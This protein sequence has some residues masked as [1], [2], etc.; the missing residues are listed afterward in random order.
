MKKIA[1]TIARTFALTA[2]LGG[3]SVAAYAGGTLSSHKTLADKAV[4]FPEMELEMSM[5]WESLTAESLG[6]D[7]QD[8]YSVAES[9]VKVYDAENN[10]IAEGRLNGVGFPTT[11]KLQE[12]LRGASLL[13]TYNG[14][15][16]YRVD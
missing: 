11:G 1:N 15:Q 12:V 10:L 3:F 14:V 16:Y 2:V 6:I 7:T 9:E 4:A 8:F 13:M 5:N